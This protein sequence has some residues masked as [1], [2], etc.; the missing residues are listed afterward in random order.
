[1]VLLIPAINWYIIVDDDCSRTLSTIMAIFTWNW[2]WDIST[3]MTCIRN[4]INQ[5]GYWMLLA[6]TIHGYDRLSRC[7][8]L[9]LIWRTSWHH[10]VVMLFLKESNPSQIIDQFRFLEFKQILCDPLPFT[11]YAR[12]VALLFFLSDNALFN[13]LASSA[14]IFSLYFMGMH[15]WLCRM[16]THLDPQGCVTSLV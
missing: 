12:Q 5:D 16:W 8:W 2:S 14:P 13:H 11:G 3:Q 15:H 7:S 4:W 6:G 10:I 1:M 9:W